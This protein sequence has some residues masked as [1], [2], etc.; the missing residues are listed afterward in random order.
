L[1]S[2]DLVASEDEHV[3]TDFEGLGRL[4]G[5]SVAFGGR[6]PL[7]TRDEKFATRSDLVEVLVSFLVFK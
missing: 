5:A 2:S 7:V 1:N 4:I 3:R 6:W